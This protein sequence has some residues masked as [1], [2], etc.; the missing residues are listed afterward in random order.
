MMPWY[1]AVILVRPA[2][3]DANVARVCAALG[4]AR[5]TPWQLCLGVLRLWHRVLFRSSTVG[6][7]PGGRVRRSVRARVLAWRA[8]RLPCLLVERAVVPLDFTGLG[9]TPDRLI[10]HLLGAHH[11]ANQFVYDLELLAC[12]GRL[13][14]LR[15]HVLDVIERDD[16]RARWLR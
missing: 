6:T 10:R 8:A 11:D 1:E 2:R 13:D 5:P 9:S 16:A 14:E 7:S 15:A 4:V 12:H 3:I